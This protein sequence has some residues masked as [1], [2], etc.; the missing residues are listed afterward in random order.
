M[1]AHLGP[2]SGTVRA[3]VVGFRSTVRAAR[4]WRHSACVRCGAGGV[5]CRAGG[6]G[7]SEDA[8][9][10]NRTEGEIEKIH[11][12]FSVKTHV[13]CS[14]SII[15]LSSWSSPLDFSKRVESSEALKGGQSTVVSVVLQCFRC[16]LFI[17]TGAIYSSQT[18]LSQTLETY[19]GISY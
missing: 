10:I 16:A 12:F 3:N 7:A 6:I 15:C 4:Y 1:W 2:A 5:R 14:S 18:G 13:C 8:G 11:V 9:G 19:R 17:Y